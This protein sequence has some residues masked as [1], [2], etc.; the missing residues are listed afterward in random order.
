MMRQSRTPK[1]TASEYDDFPQTI[2]SEVTR[3]YNPRLYGFPIG[4]LWP[5]TAE[6]ARRGE[7]RT[8]YADWDASLAE[9]SF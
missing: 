2:C 6:A 7:H 5:L 9:L 3:P 4:T 8:E 1:P